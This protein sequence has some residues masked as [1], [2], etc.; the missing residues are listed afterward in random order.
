MGCPIC[1]RGAPLDVVAELESSW[2]STGPEPP[3]PGY[4]CVVYRRHVEEPYELS[5]AD[6]AAYSRDVMYV[7]RA[8]AKLARPR[9]LNYE[10]HGNTIPHL[11]THLLPREPARP[12]TTAELGDVL[13]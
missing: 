7:A 4:A 9:K 3:V 6:G 10:I 11:H 8:V 5:D 12:F 1:E 2:V 13:R